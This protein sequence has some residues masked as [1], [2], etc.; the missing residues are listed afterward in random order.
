MSPGDECIIILDKIFSNRGYSLLLSREIFG[1]I[2]KV[3]II[4]TFYA[5]PS[6]KYDNQNVIHS[7]EKLRTLEESL[8]I[9]P[10]LKFT[11]DND[12]IRKSD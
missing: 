5:G 3:K 9:Q 10:L 6:Y 2:E 12:S 7:Y 8:D 11:F 1:F 4:K